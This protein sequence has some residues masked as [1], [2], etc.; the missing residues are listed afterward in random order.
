VGELTLYALRDPLRPLVTDLVE[1]EA[2]HVPDFERFRR[3][4]DPAWDRASG[5]PWV[6][7]RVF[8]LTGDSS[9]TS[10]SLTLAVEP[11][12]MD[13][14][15]W[16]TTVEVHRRGIESAALARVPAEAV[17]F[18][19]SQIRVSLPGASSQRVVLENR[20]LD[21]RDDAS[22]R[23]NLAQIEDLASRDEMEALR[24]A[25]PDERPRLWD[26]FWARRD[27]DPEHPDHSRLIEHDRRVAEARRRY[28][29]GFTD[30]ARSDRGRILILH[31]E[32]DSIETTS[33]QADA[34]DTYEV[35]RYFDSGL[36]YYFRKDLAGAYR[37]A[38]Q[39]RL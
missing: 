37:L 16:S 20:G 5:P 23:V 24:Q 8:D 38:G 36:V 15:L 25:S 18:G 12:E 27:P 33:L 21:L 3:K 4:E 28:A 9:R 14:D 39:Q 31:G 10:F 6:L 35:W 2:G 19:R 22:W 32:P 29:D 1:V 7:L 11:L 26:E 34:P 17:P 13:G 30:G